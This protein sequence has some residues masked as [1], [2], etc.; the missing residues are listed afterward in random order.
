M[1]SNLGL[2]PRLRYRSSLFD[3]IHQS[4]LYSDTFKLPVDGQPEWE[5]ELDDDVPVLE[6]FGAVPRYYRPSKAKLSNSNS[7]WAIL[8]GPRRPEEV[9]EMAPVRWTMLA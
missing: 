7:F 2:R 6:D 1:A 9:A 3:L 5:A 8:E 4:G